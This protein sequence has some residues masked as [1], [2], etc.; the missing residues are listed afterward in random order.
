MSDGDHDVQSSV[1]FQLGGIKNSLET[2]H[3][4]LSEDRVADAQYRTDTRREM[5][6]IDEKLDSHEVKL[7]TLQNK[8]D[9]M[10]PKVESLDQKA[11]MSTGAMWI[12]GIMGKMAHVVTGGIGAIAGIALEKWFRDGH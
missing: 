2:I 10:Y 12:V 7:T 3:K 9:S 1:A 8:V 4:T 6:H 5:K 11:A